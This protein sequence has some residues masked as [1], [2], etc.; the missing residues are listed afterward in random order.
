M[1][2]RRSAIA[3]NVSHDLKNPLQK[4]S[5]LL[6]HLSVVCHVNF[7]IESISFLIEMD[8]TIWSDRIV[9]LIRINLNRVSTIRLS[10]LVSYRLRLKTYINNIHNVIYITDV[11]MTKSAFLFRFF[12]ASYLLL[13]YFSPLFITYLTF[14]MN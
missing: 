1:H 3:K 4:H 5:A 6:L 12:S 8:Q 13:L 10:D 14:D 7:G 9:V 11:R 2:W